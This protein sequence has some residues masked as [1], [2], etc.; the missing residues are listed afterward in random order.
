MGDPLGVASS[1]VGI[2]AF[3]L[4]FAT[5]LQ[6]YIEAVADARESLR[7]IA[8]DVSAT[9]SALDQLH[10]FIKADENGK[11]IAND[12]G[13]QEVARLASKCKQVYT[14]VI[15][16]IAKAVSAPKDDNGE[17]L[18]DAL[19]AI[20]LDESNVRRL[21]QKL[22]WPFQEPRIKK[23][24][25]ELRWLKIS[26]L[27]HLR[28]MELAKTKIMAPT[29][30]FSSRE[31]EL[32]LQANLEKLLFSK[33]AY[34]ERIAFE[35][36]RNQ[37]KARG[38]RVVGRTRSSSS[39]SIVHAIDVEIKSRNSSPKGKRPVSKSP[40]KIG[41]RELWPS[42]LKDE[43]RFGIQ[44]T[45]PYKEPIDDV[46]EYSPPGNALKPPKS[47]SDPRN[48]TT[49]NPI[50]YNQISTEARPHISEEIENNK[51]PGKDTGS[52]PPPRGVPGTKYFVGGIHLPRPRQSNEHITTIKALHIQEGAQNSLHAD[53]TEEKRESPQSHTIGNSNGRYKL[54]FSQVSLNFF[55]WSPKIFSKRDRSKSID[56]HER[57]DLEAYLIEGDN[58]D[59]KSNPI[60][61]LPFSHKQLNSTLKRIVRSRGGDVW[62]QYT[63]LTSGQRECV[64]RALLKAHQTS[65]HTRT[66]VAISSGKSESPYVTVFF[67][68]GV[69][70]Q[71]VHFKYNSRHFQF[72]FE[73]CR[74]W[75]GMASLI[76][77]TLNDIPNP[78]LF[79]QN[80]QYDLK[81]SDDRTI[82]PSTWSSTVQPG[83]TVFLIPKDNWNAPRPY[84]MPSRPPMPPPPAFR[85][86]ESSAPVPQ[87]NT[88]VPEPSH[89][90]I[91]GFQR[92]QSVLPIETRTIAGVFHDPGYDAEEIQDH[93]PSTPST[94]SYLN[95]NVTSASVPIKSVRDWYSSS[96][97]AAPRSR[98]RA[99]PMPNL[100]PVA[101]GMIDSSEDENEDE[102]EEES[103]IIDFEEEEETTRLGLEELL[104]KWTNAVDAPLNEGT[105]TTG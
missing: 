9:A 95:S 66:C 61:K 37:R 17:V 14:A 47:K 13:V 88:L 87:R 104:G 70:T 53:N 10:R 32:A 25:E 64:D 18:I 58:S 20:D 103:D 99:K 51:T 63:S 49:P 73:L 105:S 33:Q 38:K 46:L 90:T 45:F 67:S 4:K 62:T 101:R 12:S 85:M 96:R 69:S 98:R 92:R 59:P 75:E 97:A 42:T 41:A 50:M 2:A 93:S 22:K 19:D 29:R 71:P 94:D 39:A 28:L 40:P 74:T 5:T 60:R 81:D 80:G 21:V 36:R 55:P 7:D 15:N 31:K 52:S 76:T 3:G 27:F 102:N 86:P 1:I 34:V 30:S 72:S 91:P 48:D 83:I 43:G 65:S 16:L 54:K 89:G 11:S 44:D 84:P 68:L 24:Q 8:F 57:H 6:T 26:L 100:I 35:R 82:L 79:L 78:D 23:H 56:D 77:S